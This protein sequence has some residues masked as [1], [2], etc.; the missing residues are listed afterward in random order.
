MSSESLRYEVTS[1]T[2]SG[3]IRALNEDAVAVDR[4][5]GFAVVTD[6]MGGHRAGD[7][8]SRLALETIVGRL[9]ARPQQATELSQQWVKDAIVATNSVI[10]SAAMQQT[11]RTGMGTTLA[12]LVFREQQA[13]FAHVGDSRIYRLRD[14]HLELLT[15]DDSILNDQ[16][17]MGMLAAE[18]AGE[19]HNR[20]FV[21][22]ALGTSEQV[23]VHVREESVNEG[24]VYLL[25]TD[26]LND[27]VGESDI[28][29]I[30]DSLKTN[31]PLTANHLVQL[32]NDSGGYDNI[33]VALV[34]VQGDMSTAKRQGWLGRLFGRVFH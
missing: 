13:I 18:D 9:R 10:Y 30:I 15:R 16:V 32:A 22:Q 21:T 5:L 34:R 1:L 31:L 24:D 29:L 14:G 6:G 12:M 23:A 19:S 28:Q 2:D 17:E 4:E 7:V 33:T 3:R 27:L 20:H 26:G 8:A 25:C 11:T